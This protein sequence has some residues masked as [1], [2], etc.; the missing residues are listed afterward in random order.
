MYRSTR[1]LQADLFFRLSRFAHWFGFGS[2]DDWC[3]PW[4]CSAGTVHKSSRTIQLDFT[5]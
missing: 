5:Y 3:V 4:A 2:G 1:R